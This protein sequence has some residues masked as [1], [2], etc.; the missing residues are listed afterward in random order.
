MKEGKE[1]K[2]SDVVRIQTKVYRDT[3]AVDVCLSLVRDLFCARSEDQAVK[4]ET[5]PP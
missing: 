2:L 1:K 5:P 4:A 3:K